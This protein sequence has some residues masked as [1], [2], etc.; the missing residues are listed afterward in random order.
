MTDIELNKTSRIT[1]SI[2]DKLA[3][4]HSH[5]VVGVENIAKSQGGLLVINH[6]LATYDGF[7]LGMKIYE[8]TGRLIKG[9]GDDMLFNFPM[10]KSFCESVGIVPASYE[11]AVALL[12]KGEIIGLSPG[13]M[14][15]S[16]KDSSQ[17][18]RVLWDKRKG[19]VKLSIKANVPI[20][21]AACPMAD[22]IFDIYPSKTT[23]A[24]YK[25]F[26]FP[27]PIFKGVGL[28]PFPKKI[29]LKHFISPAINPPKR[30]E[31]ETFDEHVDRFHKDLT[32]KMNRLMKKARENSPV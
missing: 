3:K 23:A 14:R 16:L 1:K 27:F 28:T 26:K 13:G 6:S 8:K 2:L 7:I 10:T 32:K 18:Y 20:Y 30:K 11:N 19:F 9:L 17:K 24:I 15:E 29:K 25:N 31:G 12:K 22:D 4:Y 5:S 21:L